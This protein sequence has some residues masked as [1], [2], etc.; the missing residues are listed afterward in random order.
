M[1]DSVI[2]F[3]GFPETSECKSMTLIY[4]A[5]D[6]KGLP[7]WD[8]LPLLTLLHKKK[9]G[10]IDTGVFFP[11]RRKEGNCK[12]KGEDKTQSFFLHASEMKWWIQK[13]NYASNSTLS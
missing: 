3:P 1:C 6:R 9:R 2:G 5:E 11:S 8:K 13:T 12:E 7:D 4:I 10:T